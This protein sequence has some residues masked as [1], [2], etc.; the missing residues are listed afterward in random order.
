MSFDSDNIPSRLAS[1]RLANVEVVH[2]ENPRTYSI[3][4]S[5]QRYHLRVGQ[6]VKL[7]FLL[8][9]PINDIPDAERMWVEVKEVIGIHYVGMLDND[10]RY[11][12]N[13]KAGDIIDFGPEH[14]A[15]LYVESE[16]AQLPYGQ[17]AWVSRNLLR[18]DAWP[19]R[20]FRRRSSEHG[21][22]GWWLLSGDETESEIN[23]RENFVAYAVDDILNRFRVLDSVLDEPAEA[24]WNWNADAVEYQRAKE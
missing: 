3:P 24:A 19:H 4:R 2:R 15:G 16:E 7:V 21:F 23:N 1:H 5:G 20:L 13:L 22:S 17:Y 12:T 6:L 11:I 8:D 9:T 10:P 14:V 18:E